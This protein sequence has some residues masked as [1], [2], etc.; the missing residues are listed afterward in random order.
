MKSKSYKTQIKDYCDLYGNIPIEKNEIL[1]YLETRLKLTEKDKNKI[2]EENEYVKCI[3]WE[4]LQIVL[5]IIPKP[6]P[7]PRYSSIGNRF[8]VTGAAENKKL[9]KYFLEEKYNIIYTQTHFSVQTFI[10]TP[11]KS[12]NRREIYRAEQGE[13]IPVTTPDW[14]NLGKTYSDMIQ[15]ILILND[16]IISKGIVEKYYSVKPRVI[17][18]IKY[19]KG[20]D[21][22]FNKRKIITT[23]SYKEAIEVGNLIEIYTEGND[24]W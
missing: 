7:R 12:M 24:I 20:Y 10:P 14:D 6:S 1:D 8:Y 3:P 2:D 23:K 11:I 9:L 15:Q 17:I 21:S 16:N 4:S 13:I 19:Q 22:R 5:P 18:N